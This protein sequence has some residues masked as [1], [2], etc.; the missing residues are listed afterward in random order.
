[1]PEMFDRLAK[2]LAG[3]GSRRDALKALGGFLIGGFLW[4]LP[5]T[6]RADNGDEDDQ[7]DKFCKMRCKACRKMGGT[8]DDGAFDRCYDTCRKCCRD[9]GTLCGVCT[10]TNRAVVCCQA[11]AA[12]Y[13]SYCGCAT[14]SYCC[15]SPKTGVPTCTSTQPTNNSCCGVQCK[16]GATC[17]QD[18]DSNAYYCCSD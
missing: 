1:M 2:R 6:A 7:D 10:D 5:G 4:G 17:K 16:G 18:D 9:K 8:P 14:Q 11:A 13:C 3:G 15:V 12:C